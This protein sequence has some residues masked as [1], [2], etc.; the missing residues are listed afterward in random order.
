VAFGLL[1]DVQ[2]LH[3]LGKASLAQALAREQVWREPSWTES[4]VVGS[5]SFVKRMQPLILSR[6]ETGIAEGPDGVWALH[7]RRQLRMA[8]KTPPKSD[9]WPDLNDSKMANIQI[10]SNLTR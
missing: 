8:Q 10:A 4:L 2:P 3:L 5:P 6:Q 1:P 9:P 7:R